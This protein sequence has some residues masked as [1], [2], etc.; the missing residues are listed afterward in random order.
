MSDHRPAKAFD[1]SLYLV[2]DATLCAK[3]GLIDTVL[4]A[5]RG[6]VTMVQLRDKAAS[7]DELIAQ[8]RQL[9]TALH[10]TGVA[11]IINDRLNVAIA[12]GADGLHI[13]QGDGDV[14]EARRQLGP[15]AILGLSVE[16][17]AQL[18][19]LDPEGLDYIGIGPVFATASKQ[20]H[21]PPLG[22]EGLTELVASSP[23]PSVAIGGL[24]TRH[25]EAIRQSGANGLAVISAICG[26][27]DPQAA[28]A[29]FG[30]SSA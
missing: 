9:M 16:N 12:A 11:L 22:M 2:T 24:N 21:A 14:T 4:A 13:G 6:G 29:A 1:L 8:A 5:V 26:Q 25:V 7:D 10:D 17:S 30:L 23:L 15:D 19:A 3:K 28:A 27:P 18:A 20:D